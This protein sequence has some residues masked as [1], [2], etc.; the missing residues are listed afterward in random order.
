VNKSVTLAK[1]NDEGLT[2]AHEAFV[3]WNVDELKRL[4]PQLPYAEKQVAFYWAMHCRGV[5]MLHY[6]PS[7]ES[8]PKTNLSLNVHKTRTKEDER[9]RIIYKLK[10]SCMFLSSCAIAHWIFELF[11]PAEDKY[12]CQEL[13]VSDVDG[14]SRPVWVD[15][16]S[17][18]ALDFDHVEMFPTFDD[19]KVDIRA[20][21]TREYD[22][23]KANAYMAEA[24][25]RYAALARARQEQVFATTGTRPPLF[26]W[27]VGKTDEA[28][29]LGGAQIDAWKA[30]QSQGPAGDVS[31]PAGDVYTSH[32]P[33]FLIMGTSAAKLS[34]K[35]AD[36]NCKAFAE[37][38]F[39]APAGATASANASGPA[40][41]ADTADAAADTAAA[42]ADAAAAAAAAAPP[43]PMSTP[44][45]ARTTPGFWEGI[46]D[47]ADMT[48]EMREELRQ[49]MLE[50]LQD[51]RDKWADMIADVERVENLEK[52]GLEP[53]AD[54]KKAYDAALPSVQRWREGLA[55]GRKTLEEARVAEGAAIRASLEAIAVEEANTRATRAKAKAKAKAKAARESAAKAAAAKAVAKPNP[56]VEAICKAFQSGENLSVNELA[57]RLTGNDAFVPKAD[58]VVQ[59]G[60]IRRV[61]RARMDDIF[62]Q[63][64]TG[65]PEIGTT[66]TYR[67]KK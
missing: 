26:E 45:A 11:E 3:E 7:S 16:R 27:N 8:G 65:N 50:H 33:A 20:A 38:S 6:P 57:I 63:A 25:K 54:E 37:A 49:D 9:Q 17:A 19:N 40:S 41:A 24:G 1:I 34:A 42:D 23:E 10:S 48:E 12:A 36:D 21:L 59:A 13:Y 66:H 52:A 58:E 18:L 51:I 56:K 15:N 47:V 29:P 5:C 32:H 61:I 22:K 2:K 35:F 64:T 67:L 60:M 43:P 62:E 30:L 4:L 44:I 55:N 14:T 53:S 31:S 28:K 46:L 39:G